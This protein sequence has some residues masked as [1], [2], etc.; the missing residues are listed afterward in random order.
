[1]ALLDLLEPSDFILKDLLLFDCHLRNLS[2]GAVQC[3]FED[4][5]HVF[6]GFC[7]VVV[8]SFEDV[9][10]VFVEV[11]EV[12]D[13]FDETKVDECISAANDAAVYLLLADCSG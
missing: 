13:E 11:V 5:T 8:D 6:E 1:M 10:D 4:I 2:L 7:H 12:G 9:C 3:A